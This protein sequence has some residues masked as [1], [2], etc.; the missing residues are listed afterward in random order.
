MS[1]HRRPLRFLG[2]TVLAA[3]LLL[4]ACDGD[5]D[6]DPTP[7]VTA[8]PTAT[9]E[10]TAE[11]TATQ[12]A[13]PTA[14]PTETASPT[15]TATATPAG[16]TNYQVFFTRE[17]VPEDPTIVY[18][19]ER[20]ANASDLP[21]AAVVALIEGPTEA[22]FAEG[23][24]SEWAQ[25]E[26]SG[27]PCDGEPF[28]VGVEEVTATVR[29]CQQPAL[30]GVLSDARAEAQMAATLSAL[31]GIDRVV[32]LGPDGNCLF[33]ASGENLCLEADN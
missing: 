23:F 1:R 33:D 20:S 28:E 6:P 14:T 27:E 8:T 31:P 24:R 22:E 15:A 7:T 13:S 10:P 21:G 19:S 11:A 9:A 25:F 17:P 12:T 4:A 18:A 2:L 32:V 5:D 26:Y 30:S 16:D 29:F 3:T